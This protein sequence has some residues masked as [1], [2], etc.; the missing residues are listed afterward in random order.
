MLGKLSDKLT[1][2]KK[3]KSILFFQKASIDILAKNPLILTGVALKQMLLLFCNSLNS[4][5]PR[6]KK[7]ADSPKRGSPVHLL[8]LA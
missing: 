5:L 6:S 4:H 8:N 7:V 2:T 1:P 3:Q